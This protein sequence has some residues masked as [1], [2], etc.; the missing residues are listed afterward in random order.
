MKRAISYWVLVAMSAVFAATSLFAAV[1]DFAE[2]EIDDEFLPFLAAKKRF[3]T[4]PGVKEF[5]IAGAK[6]RVVVCIVSVPSTGS[7]AS[8]I[9]KMMKVCRIKAQTELL[10]ASGYELSAYTVAEDR[11]V[12]ISDGENKKIQSMSS[13][14]NVTEEKVNGVVRSW[15]VVGT[16]FSNDRK[17]FYLAIGTVLSSD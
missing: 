13:F 8:A 11:L 17:E 4:S 1:N 2:V 7:S 9:A 10:K 5:A 3:M 14:L 16:W 15:P 12:T 6:K